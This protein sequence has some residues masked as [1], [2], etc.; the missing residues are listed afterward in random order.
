MA[1]YTTA[2][3][4]ESRND[5]NSI[6]KSYNKRKE[7]SPIGYKIALKIKRRKEK[8]ICAQS[9]LARAGA[10]MHSTDIYRGTW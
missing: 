1:Q 4:F 3:T 10:R 8:E 2:Y 5:S 6:R 7:N 9:L